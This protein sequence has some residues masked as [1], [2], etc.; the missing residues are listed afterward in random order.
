MCKLHTVRNII[1]D[2]FA[3]LAVPDVLYCNTV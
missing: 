3:F 2:N 1:L